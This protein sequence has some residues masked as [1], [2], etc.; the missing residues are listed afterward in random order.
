[1]ESGRSESTARGGADDGVGEV[2]LR[3]VEQTL[4]ISINRPKVKNALNSGVVAGL[5][6]GLEHLDSNPN[7]AVGVLTGEGGIFCAGMDL[8]AFAE[9]GPPTDLDRLLVGLARKPLI[10]AVEGF[11]LAGGLELALS[12]D[13]IVAGRSARLGIPEVKVGL[14]AAGGGL[15]RLPR[16]IPQRI[17]MELALTGEQVSAPDAFSWGLI[18]RVVDDGG[19][20][21]A[22]QL[23]A[24]QIAR[25]APLSIAASKGLIYDSLDLS[26]Q[27]F[28]IK[29][30]PKWLQV[31]RSED[32][33]EGA[34]S[35]LDKR[36]PSWKGC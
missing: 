12:A 4:F 14:F 20:A 13:L 29:Q 16:A 34:R 17:A 5:V 32:A 27:E 7:L 19:A 30:A 3:E 6:A 35:F 36:P 10:A 25:N 21:A 8:K 15:L 28:R 26:S 24:E 11:A 9:S 1:M 23:L 2:I 31:V 33:K 22:A 18:N